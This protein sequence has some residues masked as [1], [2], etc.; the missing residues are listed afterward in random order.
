MKRGSEMKINFKPKNNLEKFGWRVYAM[1]VENF[2]QTFF[3]GGTV[4][5]L[6][7]YDN[8]ADIDIATSATP[9]EVIGILNKNRINFDERGKK[10]GVI[11][12]RKK[13]MPVAI[14]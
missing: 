11:T 7:L 4:R 3:V 9:N 2:P 13:N 5:D 6:L 8:A 10:F 12:A 1:L 14:T